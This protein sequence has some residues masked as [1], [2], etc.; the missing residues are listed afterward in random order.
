MSRFASAYTDRD[1]H[2]V[3]ATV[4]PHVNP[5]APEACTQRAF[6]A[7]RAAA[8]HPACPT[9]R[10]LTTRLNA[11]RNGSERSWAQWLDVALH[12]SA[13][14]QARSAGKRGTVKQ[15]PETI[16]A[17]AVFAL[18]LA[19]AEGGHHRTQATYRAWRANRIATLYERVR[20]ILPTDRQIRRAF[21]TWPN[22]VA[23]IA[24]E[25]R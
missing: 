14:Y 3:I 13:E 25:P 16:R 24:D 22:A 2:S 17:S 15:A 10:Q 11:N 1:L 23:A 4:A 5:G 18:R 6:D 9:A 12:Q 7:A 21:N 20:P 19:R 8:G